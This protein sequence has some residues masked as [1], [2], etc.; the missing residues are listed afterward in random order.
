MTSKDLLIDELMEA[1]YKIN[2]AIDIVNGNM[3]KELASVE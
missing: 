2:E 3:K 1:Q